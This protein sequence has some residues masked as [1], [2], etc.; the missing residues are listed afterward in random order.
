MKL[1]SL[2]MNP[3]VEIAQNGAVRIRK[4]YTAVTEDGA[5]W[6]RTVTLINGAE[7]AAETTGWERVSTPFEAGQPAF[8]SVASHVAEPVVEEQVQAAP[9]MAGMAWTNE[10]EDRLISSV[11]AKKPLGWISSQHGRSEGSI[12][13][14]IRQIDEKITNGAFRIT[15][16]GV[17]PVHSALQAYI[18]GVSG[19]KLHH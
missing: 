2:S 5:G 17:A 9:T 10:E 3:T 16:D 4:Y 1:V 15:G 11:L 6:E 13:S 18:A 14:R 12:S 19:V 7:V 8:G